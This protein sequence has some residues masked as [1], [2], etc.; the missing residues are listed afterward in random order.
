MRKKLLLTIT[1]A[2]LLI[3][4]TAKAGTIRW[5]R[6]D[7]GSLLVDDM[8]SG[9]RLVLPEEWGSAQNAADRHYAEINPDCVE[10]EPKDAPSSAL[11]ISL[12]IP[13]S[14]I[15]STDEVTSWAH[16]QASDWWMVDALII[17]Y[18]RD[19]Q[20][21]QADYAEDPERGKQELTRIRAT[22][23][24]PE[25]PEELIEKLKA[26]RVYYTGKAVS[27]DGARSWRFAIG[28][29]IPGGNHRS[30]DFPVSV[31]STF[32][33]IMQ[34]CKKSCLSSSDLYVNGKLQL[35]RET[36]EE[37]S[38]V[39]W[40]DTGSPKASA[41][42]TPPEASP[43]STVTF[44]EADR[45]LNLAWYALPKPTR[46][47]LLEDQRAWLKNRDVLSAED[48]IVETQNRTTYLQSLR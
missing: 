34:A 28:P 2:S 46:H 24:L 8:D 32:A 31:G 22:R 23:A 42:S 1:F 37:L 38:W 25:P 18:R 21:A 4:N 43:I 6:Y 10:P 12:D 14:R 47:R 19:E 26:R 29:D 36:Q 11:S 5:H 35:S 3:A 41:I 27:Y 20:R 45:Q 7:D 13:P 44:E 48:K 17:A 40:G 30:V 16:S 15:L 33:Q 9:Q 39:I